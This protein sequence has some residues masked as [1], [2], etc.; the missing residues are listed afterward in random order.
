RGTSPRHRLEP[1]LPWHVRGHRGEPVH[2][3]RGAAGKCIPPLP[4]QPPDQRRPHHRLCGGRDSGGRAG[5]RR[6]RRARSLRRASRAALGGCG[7]AGLDRPFH[8]R[9]RSD[10]RAGVPHR[11]DHDERPWPSRRQTG[12]DPLGRAVRRRLRLGFCALRHGL[13]GAFL[14]DAVG[15]VAQRRHRDAGFRSRH[16]A[17]GARSGARPA[18]ASHADP[19]A[20]AAT[21]TGRRHRG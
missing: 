15:L 3:V 1:A 12:I 5:N 9:L 21:R 17:A 20:M 11:C 8:D 13:R 18:M 4:R 19:L 6:V 2:G 10:S 7:L 16:L 14:R